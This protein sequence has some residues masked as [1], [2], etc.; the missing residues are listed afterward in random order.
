[1]SNIA[2]PQ[3]P[4]RRASKKLVWAFLF[5]L[6][7]V[8]GFGVV[9]TVIPVVSSHVQRSRTNGEL[10]ALHA[11]LEN[12]KADYGHYPTDPATTEK[13]RTNAAPDPDGYIAASAFLY[14]ALMGKP[15]PGENSNP[16]HTQYYPLNPE[17][18]KTTSSGETYIVDEWGN[19][20]GYST[21]EAT[22]PGSHGGNNPTY[23]LWST[24]GKE[25]S[26]DQRKWIINW[27]IPP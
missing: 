27:Q 20:L 10:L 8:V 9:L 26:S 24:G 11:A 12:Y 14:R 5:L 4:K 18:L 13:L 17:E 15:N 1:M 25:D 22:H 16:N 21:L 23:D 7:L 19:C 2:A 3:Q 6:V